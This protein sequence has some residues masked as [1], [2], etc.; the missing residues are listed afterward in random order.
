MK[1]KVRK[2]LSQK[3]SEYQSGTANDEDQKIIDQ[4]FASKEKDSADQQMQI[5][6]GVG[7]DIFSGITSQISKQGQK[8]KINKKYWA[9]AASVALILGFASFFLL[10]SKVY[11]APQLEMVYDTFATGNAEIKKMVLPDGT[12]IYLNAGTVIRIPRDFKGAVKRNVMLDRGEAFFEVKRDTLR[13]FRIV[14]GQYTTTVLGTS[15][16][17]NAYPERKGYQVAVR[18]GKVRVEKREGKHVL[19]LGEN[20]IKNQ[21]L[22]Y[23]NENH[24]TTIANK[25]TAKY[26]DWRTDRSAYLD[27][28]DLVQIGHVLSRQYNIKVEVITDG[29]NLPK[30]SLSLKY[31]DLRQV[32]GYLAIKTGMNYQLTDHALIINPAK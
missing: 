30:Y 21:V 14:T 15:F 27:Q 29:A 16:N 17:I 9:I 32:L 7:E 31:S 10:K 4:W 22:S 24:Q 8:P 5:G 12:T 20:L 6:E 25:P 19:V 1:S 23:N 2:F 26:A 18:T 3:L 28:M 13:P 11:Q